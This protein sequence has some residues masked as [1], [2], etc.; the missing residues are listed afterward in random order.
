MKRW[1]S[2]AALLV[3]GSA[4]AGSGDYLEATLLKD[5]LTYPA[6]ASSDP[7]D[8]LEFGGKLYF[9]AERAGFGREI[10]VSDGQ[11]AEPALVAEFAPANGNSQARLLGHT[12]DRLIVFARTGDLVSGQV[13]ALDPLSG[14]R[15]QLSAFAPNSLTG[16]RPVGNVGHRVLFGNLSDN[17]LWATDGTVAGT[18]PLLQG[19]GFAVDG[20]DARRLCPLADKALFLRRAGTSQELWGSDGTVA[21]T[22]LV[23]TFANAGEFSYTGTSGGHCY[24]ATAGSSGG[25]TL[26]RTDGTSGGSSTALQS[27][28]GWPL[29]VTTPDHAYVLST[30]VDPSP[31]Y[32]EDA[33]QP[34]AQLPASAFHLAAAG[35]ALAYTIGTQSERQVQVLI[36]GSAPQ[37]VTQAGSP[38]ALS[39]NGG[40]VEA[41]GLL[42][43]YDNGST[44]RIDASTATATLLTSDASLFVTARPLQLSGVLYG[45]GGGD[46]G[47]EVWRSDGTTAGTRLLHDV[48]QVTLGSLSNAWAVVRDNVLY[49]TAVDLVVD[50]GLHDGVWRSD[51]TG[52]GTQPLPRSAYNDGNVTGLVSFGGGFAFGSYRNSPSPGLDL[53]RVDPDFQQV[54]RIVAPGTVSWLPQSSEGLLTFG[55][56]LASGNRSLCAL[57]AQDGVTATAVAFSST[58]SPYE[59]IGTINGVHVY[60][61]DGALWRSD[62]TAPGT[63]ALSTLIS[64]QNWQLPPPIIFLYPVFAHSFAGRLY[65]QACTARNDASCSVYGTD[66]T[67]APTPIA[68]APGYVTAYQDYQGQFV[69]VSGT[70]LWRSSGVAATTQFAATIAEGAYNFAVAGNLLHF[71]GSVS[72]PTPH[73]GYFVSDATQA[74]TRAVALPPGALL[75]SGTT[76][77][78]DDDVL[79]RCA[80]PGFGWELCVADSAGNGVHQI[81]DIDSGSGHSNA[82]LLARTA[83]ALYVRANDGIHGWE[84]WRIVRRTDAIFANAFE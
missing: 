31:L 55:C 3:A 70:Q 23:T 35:G 51:G 21:G 84:P 27:P 52:A 63:F 50:G 18:V 22:A 64:R 11:A 81:I 65:F 72:S 73:V 24:F 61:R 4:A 74:G 16:I 69:F 48:N 82:G 28:S 32:R 39:G 76:I 49:F 78:F 37:P 77:P 44:W 59:S 19:S 26:W 25:W 6:D 43:A 62:G 75:D 42:L 33:Q 29:L 41:G 2:L 67:T 10:F 15:T 13:W 20:F 9:S 38:L 36:V 30:G 58:D 53:F 68:S 14:A 17:K 34:V 54:R 7:D 8:F 46:A 56:A 79:F 5:V 45:S 80:V 1:A 60:F 83:D 71:I 66:G 47:V 57:R 40:V 12:S